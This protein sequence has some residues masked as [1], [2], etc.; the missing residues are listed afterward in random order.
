MNTAQQI[1]NH[2]HK[3][4]GKYI[5]FD[6]AGKGQIIASGEHSGVVVRRARDAGVEVPVIL[7]VPKKDAAYLY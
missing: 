5:A 1:T 3:V 6:P 2:E 7:F 4:E